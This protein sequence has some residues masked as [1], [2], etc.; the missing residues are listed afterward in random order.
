[1]SVIGTAQYG[2]EDIQNAGASAMDTTPIPHSHPSEIPPEFLTNLSSH[3]DSSVQSQLMQDMPSVFP[4]K[5]DR[6]N[7]LAASMHVSMPEL[8]PSV[9]MAP[10]EAIDAAPQLH[11]A[12]SAFTSDYPARDAFGMIQPLENGMSLE[13]S[14]NSHM[15]SASPP[16]S[17]VPSPSI[18]GSASSYS[19]GVTSSLESALDPAG[20]SGGR[21]RAN[22]SSVSPGT[23]P[24][25]FMS[26][27]SQQTIGISFPPSDGGDLSVGKQEAAQAEAPTHLILEDMLKE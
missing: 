11:S 15:P 10:M 26:A 27:G 24:T 13:M 23:L 9:F 8:S 17:Q 14:P 25:S 16:Q 5:P 21:S 1:M 6:P 3:P 18:H 22:T 12:P 2:L 4:N 20:V 7:A 19:V